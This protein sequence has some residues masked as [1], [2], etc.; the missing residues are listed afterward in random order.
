MVQSEAHP[1][2][3]ARRYSR[4]SYP[5]R[6][7][8]LGWC[9]LV[10]LNAFPIFLPPSLPSFLLDAGLCIMSLQISFVFCLFLLIRSQKAFLFE[11]VFPL[12]TCLCLNRLKHSNTECSITLNIFKYFVYMYYLDFIFKKIND[13]SINC[14]N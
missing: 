4:M 3:P 2:Q 7:L 11:S 1:W 5:G 9:C 10:Y 13:K 8:Y 14:W 6:S 12:A